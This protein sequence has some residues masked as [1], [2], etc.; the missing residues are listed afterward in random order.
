MPSEMEDFETTKEFAQ[1]L[2]EGRQTRVKLV[3]P[4][5]K[6]KGDKSTKLENGSLQ[7]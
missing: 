2:Q 6:L 3:L 5:S 4:S 7:K 1:K